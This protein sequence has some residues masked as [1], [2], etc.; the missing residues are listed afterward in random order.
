MQITLTCQGDIDVLP[1][2]INPLSNLRKEGGFIGEIRAH[3]GGNT[4]VFLANGE[5]DIV[6]NGRGDPVHYDDDGDPVYN[7]RHGDPTEHFEELGEVEQSRLVIC[8][9]H[10]TLQKA[11]LAALARF[12]QSRCLKCLDR[13]ECEF[14]CASS[15]W[16]RSTGGD[17]WDV[18]VQTTAIVGQLAQFARSTYRRNPPLCFD[19]PAVFKITLMCQG[20]MGDFSKII[21]PLFVLRKEIG[22]IGEIRTDTMV[23]T[24]IV[25]TEITDPMVLTKIVSTRGDSGDTMMGS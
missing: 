16:G 3:F 24:E 11:A 23:L 7:N 20:S 2:I 8:R 22:F 5:M 1:K 12:E 10:D 18:L 4:M 21:D 17:E 19:A 13:C 25:A 15:H 9:A 14:C 6:S